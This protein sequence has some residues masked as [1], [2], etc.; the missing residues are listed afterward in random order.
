MS[1]IKK[2]LDFEGLKFLWSKIS[3]EDYPNNETLATVINAIDQTKANKEDLVASDWNQTDEAALDYIKNKPNF[4]EVATSGNWNDLI[5]TPFE[6]TTSETILSQGETTISA[7]DTNTR[8]TVISTGDIGYVGE[9]SRIHFY[10]NS[11]FLITLNDFEYRLECEEYSVTT[12]TF[13]FNDVQVSL[14]FPINRQTRLYNAQ[15]IFESAPGIDV[16]IHVAYIQSAT[17]IEL[18]EDYVST[19]IP[20]LKEASVGQVAVVKTIDE[21]GKPIEWEAFGSEEDA[22][23]ILMEMEFIEPVAAADGSVFTDSNG[24]LYSL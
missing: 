2:F 19:A 13:E 23:A 16:N 10:N 5:D 24:A 9:D 3:M 20:R 14:M 4:A 17:K 7:A 15:L 12:N 21:N 18:F 8:I 11:Y 22:L 1:E 6:K